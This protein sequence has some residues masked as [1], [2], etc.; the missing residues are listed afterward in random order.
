[1][2]EIEEFAKTNNVP[3]L[4]PQ[5]RQILID[6]IKQNNP[7]N[8][9]EIGT[10]IGF[11]GCLMLLNSKNSTLTTVEILPTMVEIAKN[12]FKKLGL[13][14]R[15]EILQGDAS[16]IV[17]ELANPRF[18]REQK[19]S[20]FCE[21]RGFAPD[22]VGSGGFA[23]LYQPQQ[24]DFIFLDGPKSHYFEQLPYLLKLL[25]KDGLILADN[26]LFM[27]EVLSDIYPKHKHRTIIL[28]LR[29]F[30]ETVQ[31]NPSLESKIIDIEDGLILIKKITN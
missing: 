16:E 15:V 20:P 28:K 11:S 30:I 19:S 4:R 26:V 6:L 31:S 23:T 3:I 17:K 29:K 24:F 21:K 14:N 27:G 2:K 13:E 22:C 8:I 10:A 7:K 12:N 25:K 1:M 5:S 9:L 18:L